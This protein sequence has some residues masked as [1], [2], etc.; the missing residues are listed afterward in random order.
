MD[1]S[2]LKFI[3]ELVQYA[4]KNRIVHFK[5]FNVEFEIDLPP[6]FSQISMADLNALSKQ[7][8]PQ[9]TDEDILMNPYAGMTGL[10]TKGSNN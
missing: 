2:N 10:P 3:D 9:V 4:I 5:G 6:R 8:M 7:S 1:G